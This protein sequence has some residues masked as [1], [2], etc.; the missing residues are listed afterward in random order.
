[1]LGGGLLRAHC[2]FLLSIYPIESNFWLPHLVALKLMPE[3]SQISMILFRCPSIALTLSRIVITFFFSNTLWG[4]SWLPIT[5]EEKASTECPFDSDAGAEV[6]YKSLELDDEDPTNSYRHYYLRIKIYD[7]KGAE[8][9]G[10]Y[11]MVYSSNSSRLGRH[12]ARI[13][14]ADGSVEEVEKSEFYDEKLKEGRR[15]SV[16][17][18]SFSLP[19]LNPGDIV[20]FQY[21]I[22][23]NDY[24]YSPD[25][26]L[27]FQERWP[28]RR[29][30][31]R[32]RPASWVDGFGFIK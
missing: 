8:S 23:L 7:E 19:D 3:S 17:A 16:R 29:A 11:R 26:F 32:V 10:K 20:D 30:K 24:Y 27:T 2:C 25:L 28:L 12:S 9:V 5:E 1:M 15:S 6:L 13:V 14:R 31:V 4:A 18:K 22:D 21:R